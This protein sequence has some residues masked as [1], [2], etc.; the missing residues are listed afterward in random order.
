MAVSKLDRLHPSGAVDGPMI[1]SS[2]VLALQVANVRSGETF[3]CTPTHVWDGDGP[4][5]CAEGPKVR[6]A[7]IA[8]R[9][10]DGV[11][12]AGHPCPTADPIASRDALVSLLG[13]STGVGRHGHI[14][15]S[16][17]TMRCTSTG[18][19]GGDR[20]GAWCVSPKSGD[21]SCAMVRGGWAARWDR[22]WQGRRCR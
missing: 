8:A 19:A 10:L 13:T 21:I 20:T 15:V 7:G 11:C 2:L 1:F 6:I 16:G 12:S 22:F 3:D 17:P 9:E 18:R 5:W 4:V 14:L